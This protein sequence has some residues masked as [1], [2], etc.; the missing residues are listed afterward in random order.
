MGLMWMW[1][2]AVVIV[3]WKL[4][5]PLTSQ[6]HLGYLEISH[7]KT[8]KVPSRSSKSS[9]S[10]C[11]AIVNHSFI[12]K[13]TEIRQISIAPVTGGPSTVDPRQKMG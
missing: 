1:S 5:V 8:I 2:V 9:S 10:C 6:S 7:N 13:V 3:Q 12:K 4:Q 11:V